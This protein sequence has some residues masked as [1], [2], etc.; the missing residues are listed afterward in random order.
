[1]FF[2]FRDLQIYIQ[3]TSLFVI[4]GRFNGQ[5]ENTIYEMELTAPD[6]WTRHAPI[7]MPRPICHHCAVLVRGKILII[8]GTT[9]GKTADATSAVLVF[10]PETRQFLDNDL[11]PL[12]DPVSHMAATVWG[13]SVVVLGGIDNEDEVRNTGILYNVNITNDTVRGHPIPFPNME[14]GRY[15]CTACSDH[16]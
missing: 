16:R 1:M 4:G 14:T 3:I 11:E 8:G 15:G 6:T 7:I 9:T 5:V 12:P 2:H 13:D 10:D